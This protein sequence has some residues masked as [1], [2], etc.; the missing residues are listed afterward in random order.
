VLHYVL[1]EDFGKAVM[2]SISSFLQK[3]TKAAARRLFPEAYSYLEFGKYA[4]TWIHPRIS[5]INDYYTPSILLGHEGID[6]QVTKQLIRLD[7]W[8]SER[9]QALFS[10]LRQDPVINDPPSWLGENVGP[11]E[12]HNG[13]YPTPDAEIYAA[14]ILDI[15]PKQIVEVGSGYSTLIARRAI[16]YA[17]LPTKLLVFDPSPRTEV[18]FAAD[19]IV[20]SPV[21]DSGLDHRNWTA[22]DIL[23]IDS[24][25]ICRS[26]GDVPFLFCQ[27]L[28]KL[29]AGVFVHVHDIFIPYDYPTNYD[30]R[31]YTEQYLL[32]CI[33]SGSS[34]YLTI[35][36]T[37]YLSRNHSRPMQEV[38]SPKVGASQLYNGASYWFQVVSG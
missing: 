11:A 12:L 1:G 35:L 16:R 9:H 34:R 15:G 36:S 30:D 31:C 26:R 23:F 13:Y 19:E 3:T 7:A 32:H 25:H 33:L 24:S 6:L 38:F 22:N 2:G 14:M 10:E 27:V 28:P 5:D 4:K 8:R 37:H 20:N 29:P 17:A 18:R 21:E